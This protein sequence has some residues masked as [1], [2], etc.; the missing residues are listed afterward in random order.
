[1]SRNAHSRPSSRA[2]SLSTSKQ[3]SEIPYLKKYYID[4]DCEEN[5]GVSNDMGKQNM[6]ARKK[7]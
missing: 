7:V 2:S 6:G 5:L 3:H 4:S 1:M